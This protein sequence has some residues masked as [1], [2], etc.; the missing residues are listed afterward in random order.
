MKKILPTIHVKLSWLWYLPALFIDCILTYPLLRWTVRRSKGI[1]FDPLV[2]TGIVL[3]QIIT[4]GLW[5]LPCYFLVTKDNYGQIY[6]I[7]AIITLG[8]IMFCFYVFQLPIAGTKNGYHL[9]MWIKL[10]GPAGSIALN[11]WKVQTS[12]QDLYH[13]FLMINYDAVFFSQGVIDMC[14][15]KQML[16]KRGELAET[17]IAPVAIVGFLL[18]YSVTS[19]TIYSNMGHLFFYPLYSVYWVQC[20]YTTG[21]WIWVYFIIW[22]MAKVGNDKFNDTAYN[23]LCGSSLYAYVSHYFFILIISVGIIRPYK[24]GFIPA[25]FIMMFGTE[26]LIFATYIPLNFIYELIVPPKQT[27]KMDVDSVVDKGDIKEM[28]KA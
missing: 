21:T 24:I 7:P 14:Y 2:D 4:L 9:A 28:E 6:L 20:L 1:P 23:L 27:K 5:C 8:A 17:A 15:W 19:P 18:V 26:F 22:M 10:V 11:Y 16:K 13:I 12:Q 3:H 25:F